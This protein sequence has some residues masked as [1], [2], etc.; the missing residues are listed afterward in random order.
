EAQAEIMGLA[1]PQQYLL[2]FDTAIL[3]R[4]PDG[5]YTLNRQ[6]FPATSTILAG[7]TLGLVAGL[8]LGAPITGATIGGILGGATSAVAKTMGIEH[9]FIHEVEK[10]MNPGTAAL[11]VLDDEGDLE[12]ILHKI[13]GTP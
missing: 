3:V 6:P 2:L 7:S 8:L 1:G 9:E 4:H 12:V 11:L 10:M 13:R 5:S